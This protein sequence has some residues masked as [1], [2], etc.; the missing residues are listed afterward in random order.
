MDRKLLP[1]EDANIK[2]T[3]NHLLTEHRRR[4]NPSQEAL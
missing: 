2:T 3:L 1:S 4:T